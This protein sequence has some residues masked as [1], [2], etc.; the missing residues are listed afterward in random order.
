MSLTELYHTPIHLDAK[1][2]TGGHTVVVGDCMF[3]DE[4]HDTYNLVEDPPHAGH[5]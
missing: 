5:V 2:I 3:D 1:G 4:R